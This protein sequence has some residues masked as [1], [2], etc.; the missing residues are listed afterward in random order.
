MLW[1]VCTHRL[2]PSN[3]ARSKF[4]GG[5]HQSLRALLKHKQALRTRKTPEFQPFSSL[6]GSSTHQMM[7]LQAHQIGHSS[8]HHHLGTVSGVAVTT[9]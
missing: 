9:A 8:G 1:N 5:R 7:L 2:C 6:S 4:H 3:K